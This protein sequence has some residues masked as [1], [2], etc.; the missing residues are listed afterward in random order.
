MMRGSKGVS[1][2]RTGSLLL[3]QLGSALG[4]QLVVVFSH[5]WVL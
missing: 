4:N 1:K 2:G 5:E 3:A